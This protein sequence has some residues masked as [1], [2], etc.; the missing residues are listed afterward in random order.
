MARIKTVLSDRVRL[1]KASKELH[2]QA[3]SGQAL[4]AGQLASKLQRDEVD[5]LIERKRNVRERENYN[6]REHPLFR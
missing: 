1:F 5:K 4:T 6:K 2:E 3:Q